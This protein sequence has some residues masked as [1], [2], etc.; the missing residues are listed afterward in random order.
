M[1]SHDDFDYF[2]IVSFYQYYQRYSKFISLKERNQLQH[3]RNFN[4]KQSTLHAA[5][6]KTL[7]LVE[8]LPPALCPHLFPQLKSAL[9]YRWNV[10]LIN[11]VTQYGLDRGDIQRWWMDSH[12]WH[13][14]TETWR[15]LWLRRST[16]SSYRI[17]RFWLFMRWPTTDL[18]TEYITVST[19]SFR[20]LLANTRM[21]YIVFSTACSMLDNCASKLLRSGRFLFFPSALQ[22]ATL[23]F[24]KHLVPNSKEKKRLKWDIFHTPAAFSCQ[25]LPVTFFSLGIAAVPRQQFGRVWRISQST[26]SA[27]PSA[28][29]EAAVM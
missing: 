10:W 23:R 6:R 24:K 1:K 7:L 17:Q 12:L 26:D 9:R 20:F 14:D 5:R 19:D 4:R 18:P 2:S 3:K 29:R 25:F 8:R 21:K 13:H 22:P 28:A 11:Q 27:T 15:P 16:V